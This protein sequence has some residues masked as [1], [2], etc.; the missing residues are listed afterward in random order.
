MELFL[1]PLEII[2]NKYF[3]EEIKKLLQYAEDA[4]EALENALRETGKAIITKGTRKLIEDKWVKG[5]LKPGDVTRFITSTDVLLL[6]WLPLEAKFHN[7]LQSYTQDENPDEI[8]LDWLISIRSA[9]MAAWDQYRASISSVDAWVIRAFVLA[10][11]PIT[12]KRKE[13]DCKI[14]ECKTSLQ[15]EGA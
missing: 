3:K 1:M 2:G 10:E 5:K 13:L 15:K 4:S 7:I 14:A 8:E 6:Y 12:K 9:F 11:K